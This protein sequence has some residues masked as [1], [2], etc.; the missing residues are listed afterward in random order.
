MDINI[1]QYR[2]RIGSFL[3]FR[4]SLSKSSYNESNK[5][6]D[7]QSSN[8]T[9]SLVL[10][11]FIFFF[12][13]Y[14][15]NLQHSSYSKASST[16]L[17][18]TSPALM[19]SDV[20][21]GIDILSHFLFT[22]VTNFQSRYTNGNRKGKG[23]KI[24]HWNKGGSFLINKMPD[25]KTIIGQHHP[26]ILGISE[27]NLLAVHNENLA[28]VQDYNLHVCPTRE[29]PALRT[30]RIVVY[31][32][33]DIVAKLRPDLMCDRYS[34]I[35]LEVGLPKHKK[36][37]VSQ[38]YREWQYTNQRG[39]RSSSSI[40]EQL[41][42]WLVFLDQWERALDTGMEVH[43]LGDMNLNHCNWMDQ[44][45]PKNNQS[46]KLRDLITALFTRILPHG[47]SQH[48]VG[49]T[50]HFP[51][52]VS[53]GLDHYYTNRP[54][55]LSQVQSFYC[56]GSDHMLITGIRNSRSFK[57]SPR[58]IRKRS[59][60][61]FDPDLF[62]TAVQN[63]S[64]LELYLC[65]EV[66]QA[67]EIF[68]NKITAILDEMAPMKTLQIRT[69]YA[70]WLSE[71]TASLMIR[72]DELLKLASET[73]CREDWVR[74]KHVRNT[75]NNRLKYEEYTWQKARLDECSNN[76][77]KTW[78]SVKGILNWQSSGSPAKL[79]Y[80]GSL[81][82]KSQDI[83]DSQ[84]EFFVEKIQQ[85]RENLP[86]PISDPLSKLRSLM[87]GRKCSFRLTSVHPDQ[88]ADI[89]SSLSN[90]T[91]F[92]L[93]QI[94]TSIIK[95]IKNEVLPAVTHMINLSI[96]S[97]KF[98][99]T[100]KKS[101][102]IPL[103]KKDDLLDPKNYRP[104]A[105]VRILSK[106]LERIVF[107]QLISYLNENNLLHP[108]HHAYRAEHNTSTA[109]IQM[110]DSWLQAVEAGELAGVCLLDMSAAFD[111]VDH[112][113]LIQKLSLY[114]LDDDSLSW[115]RSYLS[116][117][118]QSVIIEGCLSKLLQVETGVP[119]GSI[120]GPLFYTLFTNE[121]PEVIHDNWEQQE[122]VD[123]AEQEGQGWPVYHMS[124]DQGSVCCYADD[125][126]FTSTDSDP[127]VLSNKLT[128]KYKLI[129]Q[130]MVDNRLKL[131]DDKTHLLVMATGQAR[132]RVQAGAQVRIITPTE[133]IRPTSSEKLL[134]CWVHEDLKWSEHL[135]DNKKE[136]IIKSLYTRL[137]ALKKIRKIATFKNRKMIAEGIFSSKLS[138]L[139]ALWGGCGTVLKK[140]L[141]IVQNKVARIVTR[142]DWSTSAKQLLHQ[143]GWL[144]V[145]QLIFYHSVLLIYKVRLS[146]TPRYLHMMH[147]SWSYQY[148]TRQAESGLIKLVARPKLELTKSSF[149]YRGANQYNQLPAEIRSCESLPSFKV[150]AKNW[151][152]DNVS[153]Y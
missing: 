142:L 54:A 16:P 87:I 129:A 91:A 4:N 139:I 116:G 104:V 131:N 52:Q 26:H 57:T 63:V 74:F 10:A 13:L 78:K 24:G 83:A 99:S 100:W 34:S 138:Y 70:P 6:T 120:L 23:I 95:L 17:V 107:N 133:I 20:I 98:P 60:K 113:L 97:R 140:S 38:S 8:L 115:I 68:T 29:N 75:I 150:K 59:Y 149:R 127:T 43:C 22:M 28:A 134:G 102:I 146:K 50:R 33:K 27:A 147:N 143:C 25:I 151:I 65:D 66:D 72:R 36:F 144:S 44:N 89:I 108:N 137:G 76:S 21:L 56:G 39:D 94:D 11:V 67:V 101:K 96:T 45:L 73:K 55:K 1:Q 37:L 69:N 30:S 118:S 42:R 117:R 90:T 48:V 9:Y 88:V 148:K 105:I 145:N 32:H 5:P 3:P 15:T 86:P 93:D 153:I 7:N 77:A 85:I 152:K 111:V 110:Y 112:T 18:T 61:N 84:N 46:Y 64:W 81:R 125:T 49:P 136:N 123:N 121:L 53:T 71:K 109:L 12:S 119:Q 103:H 130:F 80:K 128:D 141:Q 92:G 2:A 106:I 122:P 14:F 58:Y 31:T 51:G 40:P 114:G 41:N 47:V 132:R 124:G 82:T 62:V 79:F 135:I 35:W 19:E 126:T